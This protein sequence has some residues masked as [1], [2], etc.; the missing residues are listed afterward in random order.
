MK[1]FFNST[2][3]RLVSTLIFLFFTTGVAAAQ[4]P[5]L[6]T[7]VLDHLA[8]K[9]NETVDVNIDEHLIQLTAKF[10]SS[11]E[12]DEVK[13][14]EIVNGLKGIYVKSFQFE[15]EGEYSVADVEAIR[16]QMRGPSW[17]RILNIASKK[18][19]S[20]E[21][22]LMTTANHISGLAVL[23]SNPKELTVV[24][25]VGPVDLEK[26]TQ[27]EGQF[28]IPDLEIEPTKPKKN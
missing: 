4:D 6:Q 19:G 11:K 17:S 18:D 21:V 9:A 23:A 28:G 3:V 14:K 7:A 16:S 8:A 1:K 26:L 20:I 10:L 2:P 22:H 27:L 15:N 5:R 24:N 13:V 12:P 25:I